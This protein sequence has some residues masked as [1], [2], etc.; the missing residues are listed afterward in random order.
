[1]STQERRLLGHMRT[2][3][4]S[5][6]YTAYNSRVLGA[7]AHP[8]LFDLR[9]HRQDHPLDGSHMLICA[10]A[11]IFLTIAIEAGL[12]GVEHIIE[13]KAPHFYKIF[14]SVMKEIMI[15]GIISF[16]IFIAVMS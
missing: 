6:S 1:M 12:H 7:A 2:H 13:Y 16:S 8:S 5:G 15:L 3:R 11:L 14:E 4:V 10:T 9:S